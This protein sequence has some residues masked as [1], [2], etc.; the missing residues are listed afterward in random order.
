MKYSQPKNSRVLYVFTPILITRLSAIRDVVVSCFV[1]QTTLASV[2]STIC[3][4]HTESRCH[5]GETVKRWGMG[6][7][8]SARTQ[9]KRVVRVICLCHLGACIRVGSL[10][11]SHDPT[12][13]TLRLTLAIDSGIPANRGIRQARSEFQKKV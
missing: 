10:D 5:E 7:F 4:E 9:A 13:L 12:A 1:I 2:R 8:V 11:W 6:G 3:M